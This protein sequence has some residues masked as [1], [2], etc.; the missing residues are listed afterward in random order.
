MLKLHHIGFIVKNIDAYLKT[1]QYARSTEV[2]YDPAQHSNICMLE[3]GDNEPPIELIE[4]IDEKSTTYQYL[5][6]NGNC[7][8]HLCYQ[9]DSY[10]KLEVYMAQHKL[11][12]ISSPVEAAVFHRQKVVFTYSRTQGIVEFVILSRGS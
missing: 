10:E 6:K 4:P 12:R 11:K 9:V 2:L 1:S 7:I 8:H 3:N 5:R